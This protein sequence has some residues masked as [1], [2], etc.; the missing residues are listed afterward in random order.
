M[1]SLSIFLIVL[2][3]GGIIGIV[4]VNSYNKLQYLRTKVEQAESIIDESLRTKYDLLGKINIIVKKVVKDKKDYLKEYVNLKN[5]KI[6]NFDL[7]RKLVEAMNVVYEL[8]NDYSALDKNEELNTILNEIKTTD[9]RLSAVKNYYNKNTSLSNGL[10][11]KFPSMIVAKIHKF[12]I[13]P[14]FDGKDMQD[15]I[16][17]DFK[18]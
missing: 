6:S 3:I 17:D 1:N 14:F 7:D 5:H 8:Q 16:I 11:R 10:V 18:L 12:K 2:I 13:K 15:D 9:E 4:Y